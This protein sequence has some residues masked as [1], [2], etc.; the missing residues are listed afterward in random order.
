M[1]EPPEPLMPYSY[2]SVY[3]A[4]PM[5]GKPFHGYPAFEDAAVFYRA[6]GFFVLSPHYGAPGQSEI[7]RA[8]EL[9]PRANGDFR[10]TELYEIVMRRDLQ[11]VLEAEA[12]VALPGWQGSR[13]A[14]LEVRV[15]QTVGT[16][17]F[18][19]YDNELIEAVG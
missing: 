3:I 14:S 5:A 10:N 17:V 9:D 15:A 13:G 16:P 18:S 2:M 8:I 7:D 11:L 12:V 19:A 1:T 4:G 6:A